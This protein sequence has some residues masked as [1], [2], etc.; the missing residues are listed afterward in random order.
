MMEHD[1]ITKVFLFDTEQQRH[2]ADGVVKSGVGSGDDD[3]AAVDE[4]RSPAASHLDPEA[5]KSR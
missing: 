4:H 2:L 3:P 5:A 1:W